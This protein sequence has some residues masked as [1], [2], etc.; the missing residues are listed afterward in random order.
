MP[1]P[2]TCS[3]ETLTLADVSGGPVDKRHLNR[4]DHDRSSAVLTVFATCS[5][6]G[7]T[8]RAVWTWVSVIQ[9]LAARMHL[10]GIN[11]GRPPVG[12]MRNEVQFSAE[13]GE[14]LFG[15]NPSQEVKCK[16]VS[17]PRARCCQRLQPE[18]SGR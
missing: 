16:S 12:S 8:S 11:R 10:L 5:H 17:F 4:Q 3:A 14:L 6:A 2:T 18:E 7:A 15:A 9:A 13:H 1:D